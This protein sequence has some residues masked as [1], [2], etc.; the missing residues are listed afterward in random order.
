MLVVD[1]ASITYGDELVDRKDAWP[2]Y[3]DKN[4]VNLAKNGK[5]PENVE[6]D[7]LSYYYNVERFNECIITWPPVYRQTVYKADAREYVSFNASGFIQGSYK[8]K[9]FIEIYYKKYFCQVES[10]R[11]HWLRC[12]RMISWFKDQ[13]IKWMMLNQDTIE[14]KIYNEDKNL[15]PWFHTTNDAQIKK[16]FLDLKTLEQEIIKQKNYIGFDNYVLAN[17]HPTKE[18]H[19][20]IG[21]HIKGLWNKID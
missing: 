2:Y 20:E 18:E 11:V 10:L 13:N 15:F 12:L 4:V 17:H 21:K 1:G 8:D 14:Q 6:I 19:K 3:L 5:S 7:I 16:M 9:K